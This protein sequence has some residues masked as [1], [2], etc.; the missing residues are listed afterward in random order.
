MIELF[1]GGLALLYA[2]KSFQN[3]SRKD[4][5]R[6]YSAF[7]KAY[8]MTRKHIETTRQ[9]EFG[10][11]DF[12]DIDSDELANAWAEAAE[13]IRPYNPSLAQTFDDK[14]DYWRSPWGFHRE[15]QEG[16]RRF[17]YKFRLD[18]VE[19]ELLKMEKEGV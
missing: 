19:K 8:K 4:K 14:S 5:S 11:N 18:E 10:D 13:A 9:G 15:I 16:T 1:L 17:N 6:V 7:R 12:S 3:E 2:V